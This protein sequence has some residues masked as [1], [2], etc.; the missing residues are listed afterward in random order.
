[1]RGSDIIEEYLGLT[2]DEVEK[3]RKENGANILTKTKRKSFI[4]SFLINLNDPIIRILI[5]AFFINI[6][7][8]FPNVNWF[9]SGGILASII[10]STLVSTV[11]EYSQ[12][13]AFE[14]LRENTENKKAIVRRR[15][16]IMEI[17]TGEVVKGDI[18]ILQA[19]ESICADGKIIKGE[20]SVDESALTGESNEVYKSV[21]NP[22]ALKG[23]LVCYGDCEVIVT[24]V[25]EKTYFG[26]IATE[27]NK[28]SRPSPLKKRL[29]HLAKSISIL[30]YI[31]SSLIA[32][33]YLFNVFFID[34]QMSLSLAFEKMKDIKFLLSNLLNA[35][36]LAISIIVVAVPEG[37]P[38]MITVVLSSNMKKMAKDN[39]L[40]KKMVGIETSGNIN[41]LF[42][43]K[44]GT[45][46]EGELKV[47]CLYSAKKEYL[48]YSSLSE[49]PNF[50]KYVTLCASFCN[51]AKI[52]KNKIIG[53]N[54]TDRAILEYSKRDIPKCELIKKIPFDSSKKYDSS[55]VKSDKGLI[56]LFKGTAEKI[57]SSSKYYLDENGEIRTLTLTEIKELKSKI[58]ELASNSF[59][60]VAL[61]FKNEENTKLDSLIFIGMLAIRDKVR[62]EVFKAVKQVSCAGVGVVMI[63]GDNKETAVAIAKECGIISPY[64]KRKIA[65][66]GREIGQM[67]DEELKG[68][69]KTLAVVGEALPQ[70]KT[71]LVRVSQECGYVVGMTGDGINDS[72][73][74]KNAD[75][76]FGMGSGTE[77]AKEASDIVIKDSNF[78]SIVKAILYGRTIF[79]SIRR[80]IVFQLTMNLGAVGISLIGPFIGVDNPVTITQMLWV[81]IIMDTLGA[82]AFACEPPLQKYLEE[83]PKSSSEKIITKEM[84][85]KILLNGGYILALSVWFLKSEALSMLLKKGTDEYIL[86]AFF[87]VFIFTGVFVCFISRSDEINILKSI[88]KN[89]AFVLIMLSIS[90][91]QMAFIYLGGKTF[92]A[93]PLFLSDL[94]TV[95]GISFTVVIF[96]LIRKIIF[97]ILKRKKSK[98]EICDEGK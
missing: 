21:E 43:D 97:K 53:S 58:K 66:T 35:L 61:A 76:G 60:M 30:G 75:V 98:K 88:R 8:M 1:M 79:H 73:S 83:K 33:A 81:N 57:L 32:L 36:T 20:I 70:D 47:K 67:T 40:I 6:L 19:G 52:S 96:D 50:K 29:S 94:I 38:M 64:T 71:R 93:V 26:K 34:S 48:S 13:N 89:K 24:E 56:T 84:L 82:L 45:L 22:E 9:E 87:A 49:S 31:A 23:S 44:T 27:L 91:M 2:K 63:T 12:E 15:E 7:F 77:V 65:L 28:G 14:R 69:L 62:K 16:G 41:L 37:L 54:A 25:G 90:V 39:V 3:S 42:T 78:A 5:V 10:I 11:S 18:L 80:F 51:S 72:P 46:T 17:D 95:I 55:V 4:K 59:R 86:S 92:R 68:V 74:L 85:F